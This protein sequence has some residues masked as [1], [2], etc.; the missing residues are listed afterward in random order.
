MTYA[1][2]VA[3]VVAAQRAEAPIVS[4]GGSS[5]L[6]TRGTPTARVVV[7]LH[8][9]S[10]GPR[11]FERLATMLFESGDT[12]YVPRLPHHA[13][14]A[15]DVSALALTRVD[16]LCA[17]ADETVDI[18]AGLGDQIVV[19]GLSAGANMA[20]W[21]GQTR[22]DVHRVVMIAP[23][24]ELARIPPPFADPVMELVRR[25]PNVTVRW[26]PDPNRPDRDPGFATH[27]MAEVRRLGVIVRRLAD[28]SPPLVRHLGFLLNA[29]DRTIRN[30]S[31]VDLA[32]AWVRFD[33]DLDIHAYQLSRSLSLPHDI[34][35]SDNPGAKPNVI[36][37]IVAGLT[38]GVDPG[39]VVTEIPL[40]R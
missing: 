10:N 27:A 8:G 7:F 35:E 21:V 4:P 29:N 12:A 13:E 33:S 39:A 37:P 17:M 25:L 20:A 5:I 40:T 15:T 2:A 24:F 36:Y 16:E 34:I 22:S 28:R 31:A 1:E 23:A 18:A 38:R 19:V 14:K 9:F 6:L 30:Q 3:A 32:R 11:Q 26:R